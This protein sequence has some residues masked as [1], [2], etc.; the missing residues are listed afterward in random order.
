M[1]R[2]PADE[3]T[4]EKLRGDFEKWLS[5]HNYFPPNSEKKQKTTNV[6]VYTKVGIL[7]RS[8]ILLTVFFV[9]KGRKE[10]SLRAH[11]RRHRSNAFGRFAGG[12][13]STASAQ[14][15]HDIGGIPEKD[16]RQSSQTQPSSCV[17]T[18]HRA[19][20]HLGRGNADLTVFVRFFS[21]LI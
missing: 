18:H 7:T 8:N 1:G 21:P 14:T 9:G 19:G 3:I 4:N 12:A 17:S 20:G 10:V 6:P 5:T 15:P 16:G 13:S 2:A 11:Q